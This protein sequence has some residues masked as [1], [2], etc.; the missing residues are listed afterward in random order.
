MRPLGAVS[1]PQAASAPEGRGSRHCQLQ[2][3]TTALTAPPGSP[4]HIPRPPHDLQDITLHLET[5]SMSYYLFF[6]CRGRGGCETDSASAEEGRKCSGWLASRV[7]T[8]CVQTEDFQ[9][10][11]TQLGPTF[12]R[13]S[14]P[15]RCVYALPRS[16]IATKT[17][18]VQ[19]VR[20]LRFRCRR[21][22][23]FL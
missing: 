12:H 4:V 22:S 23:V 15:N 9:K 6:Q 13:P 1:D 5:V 2:G 10:G 14:V 16:A 11:H 3:T 20:N 18:M 17:Q 8:P 21:A 19:L 7:S